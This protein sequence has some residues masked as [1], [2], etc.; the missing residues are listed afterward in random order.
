MNDKEQLSNIT[1]ALR[2]RFGKEAKAF[3]L[4]LKSIPE[5]GTVGIAYI[6]GEKD[7]YLLFSQGSDIHERHS[8]FSSKLHLELLEIAKFLT[9]ELR[10]LVVPLQDGWTPWDG[11]CSFKFKSFVCF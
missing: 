8:G 4:E 10:K 9:V 5:I 2:D 1:R 6:R 11:A 7:F 3:T